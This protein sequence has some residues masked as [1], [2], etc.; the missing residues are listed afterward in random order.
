MM[1]KNMIQTDRQA[2]DGDIIWRIRFACCIRKATR[3]LRICNSYCFFTTTMVTRTRINVT[4]VC[5]LSV[6]FISFYYYCLCNCCSRI[7]RTLISKGQCLINIVWISIGTQWISTV[8]NNRNA[9]IPDARSPVPL[10]VTFC[11]L[12]FVR[13]LYGTC[14]MWPSWLLE[15]LDVC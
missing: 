10:Y 5:S 6:L 13:I 4:F 11:R 12:I 1:W 9:R 7:C 15:F 3:A 14:C 2:S 8:Y